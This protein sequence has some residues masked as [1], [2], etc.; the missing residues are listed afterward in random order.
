MNVEDGDF[1]RC[2][3]HPSQIYTGFC[4]YCLVERLS[5]VNSVEKSNEIVEI[6][7][8]SVNE[9]ECN[10]SEVRV[11]KTLLSLFQ[12]DDSHVCESKASTSGKDFD[13][14]ENKNSKLKNPSLR[15]NSVPHIKGLRWRFIGSSKSGR[16]MNSSEMNESSKEAFDKPRHSC[17]GSIMTKALTCS[18]P[19]LDE[20]DEGSTCKGKEH[21][22]N[23][24]S[25]SSIQIDSTSN[26][27]STSLNNSS[28]GS[29]FRER[30]LEEST[31]EKHRDEKKSH[32]WSRVW[33]WSITSPFKDFTKK[34]GHNLV[35]SLSGSLQDANVHH[36]SRAN[37]GSQRNVH[38]GN[39]EVQKF[40][41]D[42]QWNKYRFGRSRS[43]HYTSPGTF[44][45][46]LL[47]FYLT[48][49]RSSRRSANHGRTRSSRLFTRGILGH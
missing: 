9:S 24:V 20:P 45:N 41:S 4:S 43:V 25:E 1:Q 35:R 40:R 16:F 49:M 33:D 5:N 39:G 10:G 31:Q 38:G 29:F 2:V 30:H 28:L 47:R 44:D 34:K 3:K 37:Q 17:D 8:S 11:R 13:S 6:S 15:S 7:T 26:S 48:P 42:S 46:G 18:F 32:R 14:S 12:L 23:V 22:K 21:K 27:N 36:A 19:C